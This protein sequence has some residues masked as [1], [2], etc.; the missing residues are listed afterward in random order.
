MRRVILITVLAVIAF[1]AILIVRM[2]AGWVIPPPPAKVAC[3]AT[4][5]TI[6]NAVCT[7]LTVQ[8]QAVGDVT[9]QLHAV[10]LLA[11]K[12][13]AHVTIARA[14]SGNAEMD[15]ESALVGVNVTLRGVKADL[16]PD[17]ALLGLLH[18]DMHGTLHLDL[19]LAHVEGDN[20]TDLQGHLEAHDLYQ[21]GGGPGSLGS[22]AVDFPAGTHPP[23]GKL[24]DLGG[25]LSVEGEVT[26]EP[27]HRVVVN[28]L[29]AARPTADPSLANQLKI[30]GTPDARG[31]RPFSLE[32]SF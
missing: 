3:A 22:Y 5:G 17:P 11:G 28:G 32:Y 9:W 4:D 18:S 13:D 8:G 2:P 14:G 10:R 20:L 6:W 16:Q 21:T 19:Q 26:L 15:V 27:Q 12:L 31:R 23:K 1:A 30:L 29:V 24:R 25:P 7:G